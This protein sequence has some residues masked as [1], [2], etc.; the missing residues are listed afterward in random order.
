[1]EHPVLV[2]ELA[3]NNIWEEIKLKSKPEFLALEIE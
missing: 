2:H 3:S 1:M